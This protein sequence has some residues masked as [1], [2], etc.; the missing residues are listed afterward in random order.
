MMLED[1]NGS[2][3]PGQSPE[4]AGDAAA[5]L[6]RLRALSAGAAD[7]SPEPEPRRARSQRAAVG[8]TVRS[9]VS[10]RSAAARGGGG[11]TVARIAAP[12]VFLVAVIALVVI[13]FQSGVVGGG[14]EVAVSPS[15]KATT[16]KGGKTA[17]PA[18]GTKVYV[19]KTG[20]TLSGIAVKFHTTT[21]DLEGLNPKLTGSTLVAG[22]KIRVPVN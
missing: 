18:S 1:H 10:R 13:L 14:S 12:A 8:S 21:S 2:G 4:I 16:T 17:T 19:V 9:A 11:R 6:E 20:D 15:P 5:A 22:A 7:Q 3:T